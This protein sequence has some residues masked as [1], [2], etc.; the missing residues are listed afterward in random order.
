MSLQVLGPE[1][2]VIDV[3]CEDGQVSAF[4]YDF[5]T[6]EIDLVPFDGPK[7]LGLA[8][9]FDESGVTALVR[10]ADGW[11]AIV[12]LASPGWLADAEPE[13]RFVDLHGGGSAHVDDYGAHPVPDLARIQR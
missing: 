2:S 7:P 6:N 11:T 13:V 4:R 1:G 9:A 12:E 10:N 5:D 8:L 3:R